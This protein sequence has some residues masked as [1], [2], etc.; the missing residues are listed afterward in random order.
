[1]EASLDTSGQQVN[2]IGPSAMIIDTT[3]D[4]TYHAAMNLN[5]I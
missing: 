3:I 2:P 5:A 1:M 4:I